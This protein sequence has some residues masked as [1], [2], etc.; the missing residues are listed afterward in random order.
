MAH[1]KD[2]E[3]LSNLCQNNNKY[4]HETNIYIPAFQVSAP[5][6]VDFST[7]EAKAIHTKHMSACLRGKNGA[8]NPKKEA[9]KI[10]TTGQ[11]H[12]MINQNK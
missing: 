12:L 8:S 4:I 5:E 3:N 2:F 11:H 6:P 10:R 1:L 7:H 9:L